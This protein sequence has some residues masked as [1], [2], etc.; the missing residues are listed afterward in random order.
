MVVFLYRYC[1]THYDVEKDENKD[2]SNPFFCMMS[3]YSCNGMYREFCL[4]LLLVACNMYVLHVCV[5]GGGGGG[6]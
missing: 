1:D 5:G 6:G 4:G 2:V 3:L